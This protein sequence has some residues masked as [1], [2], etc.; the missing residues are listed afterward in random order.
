MTAMIA[1]IFLA[2]VAAGLAS[3]NIYLQQSKKV[4]ATSV[5]N[6][7]YPLPDKP[8]IVVLPFDN[9]SGET[10]QDYIAD[11]LTE[12]FNTALSSIPEI[13]VI[14]NDTATTYKDKAVKLRQVAEELGVQFILDGSMQKSE[15]RIRV[16]ARLIDALVGRQLWS[17]KEKYDREIKNFFQIQDKITHEIVLALQ[18]ELTLGEQVRKW[19]GTTNFDVWALT[20]KGLG[21]FENYSRANNEK[22][23]ELFEKAVKIDPESAFAWVMMGWTHAM[24]V[25]LGFTKT[26]AESIKKLFNVLKKH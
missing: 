8:S 23:R 1:I 21:I 17:E 3:W 12:N 9:M 2:I 7:A 15:A 11:G 18:V 6:M 22:S 19:Y 10:N 20:A 5:N 14:A 4:E 26:P 16:T 13:F 24:D 25:R